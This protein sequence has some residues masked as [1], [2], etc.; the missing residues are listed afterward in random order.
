LGKLKY[1][2]HCP[3]FLVGILLM[4]QRTLLLL[5]VAFV[6]VGSIFVIVTKKT[7]LGLDLQG[8]TQLTLQAKTTEKV[9][10]ITPEVMKGV[11][12]VME[13]RLN[14]LGVSEVVIQLKGSD[15]ILVQLPGIK[16]PDRAERLLGD[17]AQLEFRVEKAGG[18]PGEF[19]KTDLGGSDLT[20]ATPE[21]LANKGGW[22]VAIEFTGPGGDKFAKLTADLG[23]TG[24][25][26][27]I[28]LDNKAISTPTVGPEFAGRGI[29]GGKAV[30]TGMKNAQEATE[31][32]VKLKAGALP[33]PVTV[34]ENRT[35]GA[36]LGADSVRQSLY[37]G[38]G[39][40]VLVLIFMIAYYR[41]PGFVADIAL[42]IY[43]LTTF[44]IFKL[45][46]VTLTLPGIAGFILSIG[47]AVDANVLIFERTKEELRAGKQLFTSVEAGFKRA[48][49][50]IF[51]SHITSLISCAVLFYLGT[52]LVKGFALTL[53]IGLLVNLFTAITCSRTLLLT[54]LNFPSL[55]KPSLFGV[56]DPKKAT[57][58]AAQ[59]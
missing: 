5:L 40:T 11:Q 56:M 45:I 14:G 21:S 12:T 55:R 16:D 58:Q 8:G 31:L 35:V 1:D 3:A 39:G 20:N 44:A 41:L 53:A 25:R 6:I 30:I 15:Q 7:E 46:P 27:G 26:L 9:T 33:V 28:Y 2:L 48:F 23:G 50:S 17:T 54:M 38:I 52:G 51:D 19:V 36:T 29:T 18:V 59:Q 57:A 42:V 22:E 10:Q 34:I 47:M 13:Q 32:A 37:T 49:T 4:R 43:G 24:R